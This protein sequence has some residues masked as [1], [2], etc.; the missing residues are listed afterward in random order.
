MVGSSSRPRQKYPNGG[1]AG[2]R[3]PPNTHSAVLT[4]PLRT[5]RV[6]QVRP[7]SHARES[8]IALTGK[9]DS[10]Q[11]FR[12]SAGDNCLRV[13][14]T[15]SPYPKTARTKH[16]TN[17][18]LGY[19]SKPI[20]SQLTTSRARCGRKATA[21]ISWLDITFLTPIHLPSETSVGKTPA[22]ETGL[23]KT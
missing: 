21:S 14:S 2:F 4:T 7:E 19:D 9:R 6:S 1:K 23:A 15:L 8:G 18:G 11:R 16:C 10:L 3:S 13:A 22:K 12:G 20:S 17:T 5:R